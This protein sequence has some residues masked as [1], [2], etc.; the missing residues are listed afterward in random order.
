MRLTR[1]AL[2]PLLKSRIHQLWT[3]ESDGGLPPGDLRLV[4]PN[5]RMRLIL[6]YAGSLQANARTGSW[7]VGE[8]ELA[9]VGQWDIPTVLSSPISPLATIGVEFSTTG[10]AGL[11]R[12]SMKE[13]FGTIIPLTDVL[14][15]V[16]ARLRSRASA[17]ETVFDAARLVR[18]ELVE[19]YRARDGQG[20]TLAETTLKI[21]QASGYGASMAEL[22]ARTGYSRRYLNDLFQREVGLAPGRLQSVLAFEQL[23]RQLA[24]HGSARKMMEQA[25][26]RFHDQSHFSHVFRDFT[27][28]PPSRF[29]AME[30]R[31]GRIF[32]LED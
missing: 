23:Y 12:G 21:M 28:L 9:L 17:A 3:F 27:G 22:A 14:G 19:L 26:D 2:P 11:Y 18:D 32:Y 25:L 8:G 24:L 20:E 16:G 15:H 13:L 6:P 31:F 29:A 1:F 5:G 4:V 10:F 30:N 7:T